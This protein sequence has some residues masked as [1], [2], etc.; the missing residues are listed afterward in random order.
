MGW[1][2]RIFYKESLDA[3]KMLGQKSSFLAKQRTDLYVSCTN[4]VSIKFLYGEHL[5]LKI[6][7]KRHE[8]GA[9]LWSKVEFHDISMQK[10][11]NTKVLQSVVAGK[12]ES[13]AS[14]Y[15]KDLQPLLTRA[16]QHVKNNWKCVEVHKSRQNG[17]HGGVHIEVTDITLTSKGEKWQTICFEGSLEDILRFLASSHGKQVMEYGFQVRS[18]PEFLCTHE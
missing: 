13:V 7:E 5:E 4:S 15:D 6:R 10:N 14:R 16:A 12:L 1:E 9:E 8:S 3:W 11:P 18:Y 2:W 17:H